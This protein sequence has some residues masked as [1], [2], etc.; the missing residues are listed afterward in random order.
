[1]EKGSREVANPGERGSRV[2]RFQGGGRRELTA[3]NVSFM[4]PEEDLA[5]GI[6]TR[7]D[8]SR[9]FA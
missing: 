2:E 4:I 5:L 7:F 1:M 3:N 9:A 8:H 6:G